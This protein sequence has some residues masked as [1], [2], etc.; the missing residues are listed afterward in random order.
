MDCRRTL[1]PA[2]WL[3]TGALGCAHDRGSAPRETPPP[4]LASGS[5]YAPS[6][7]AELPKREPRAST[8]AAAGDWMAGEAAALEKDT[9]EQEQ[10]RNIARKAYE[11]AI[12]INPNYIPAYQNLAHLYIEMC[13]YERAV[14]T[15]QKA[16]HL[17]PRNGSLWFD[18]GMCQARRKDWP[19][20][21]QSLQRAVDC[22]PENRQYL[23]TLGFAFARVG[24]F[25]DSLNCFM[26]SWGNEAMAQYQLARMLQHLGQMEQCGQCL[27]QALR[28]DPNFDKARTLLSQIENPAPTEVRPVGYTGAEPAGP[29]AQPVTAGQ[30]DEVPQELTPETTQQPARR[31]ILPPPPGN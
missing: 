22:D 2:L 19:A 29:D 3:L 25:Q 7:G 16:L 28:L 12:A 5:P 27:Q 18:L 15:Y 21:L 1:V 11:Q 8:C 17:Q 26:R 14:A 31:F 13:D 9:R 10:R 20:A 4:P 6:R 24:R 30:P 23:N